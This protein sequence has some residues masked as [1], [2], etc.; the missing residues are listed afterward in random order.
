MRLVI[1]IVVVAMVAAT[2]FTVAVGSDE[3]PSPWVIV[4]WIRGGDKTPAPTATAALRVTRTPAV[5]TATVAQEVSRLAFPISGAC[6]PESDAL[7]PGAPREYRQGTHEGV[8]FYES[9]NCTSI[10]FDTEVLAVKAGTVVRAD[11]AYQELTEE[12]LAELYERIEGGEGDAE[13]VKDA[14]RGRQ[15]WI[16][17]GE[18]VVTRYAH[19][20][21]IADGIGIGVEVEQGALIG[22]VGDSGTPESVTA[23]GTEIHLHFEIR[24]GEAYLG[25][26]LGAD[27][28]RR[29]YAQVFSP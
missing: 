10:G 15:V 28:V 8:D 1:A 27:E 5:P 17:H 23:P 26:G 16:D 4:E 25:E 6:L 29:L 11:L 12:T 2:L 21:G 22:Y 13:P 14:F 19:L 24:R 7:M 18:G 20:S 9:D 3:P